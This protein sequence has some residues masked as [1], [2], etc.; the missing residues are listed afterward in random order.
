[1]NVMTTVKISLLATLSLIST[2]A[3]AG[4]D[5]GNGM[6]SVS[7][8]GILS[9]LGLGVAAVLYLAKKRK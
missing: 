7:E 5:S 2:V 4:A 1:M 9:L 3:F 6:Y 8:P